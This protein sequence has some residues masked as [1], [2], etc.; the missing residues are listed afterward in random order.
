MS[1]DTVIEKLKVTATHANRKDDFTKLVTL[2]SGGFFGK[3]FCA[4]HRRTNKQ[5]EIKTIDLLPGTP[6]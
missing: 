5:V 2:G 3:V 4:H 6:T 1:Y